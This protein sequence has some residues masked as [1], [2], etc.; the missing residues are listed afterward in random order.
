MSSESDG[1]VCVKAIDGEQR[2]TPQIHWWIALDTSLS[3]STIVKDKTRWDLLKEVM[4]ILLGHLRQN[5]PKDSITVSTFSNYCDVLVEN[6]KAE[7]VNL[8]AIRCDQSTNLQSVFESFE[9]WLIRNPESRV[10]Q[11]VLT[12]GEPTS[13]ITVPEYL[14]ALQR[15]IVQNAKHFVKCPVFTWFAAI[16]KDAKWQTVKALAECSSLSMWIHVDE[17]KMSALASDVGNLVGALTQGQYY[18]VNNEQVLVIGNTPHYFWVKNMPDDVKGEVDDEL[19]CILRMQN[20]IRSVAFP[21]RAD[22]GKWQ[23]YLGEIAPKTEVAQRHHGIIQA[24]LA[25]LDENILY[26]TAMQD[27]SLSRQA[28]Q[29]SQESTSLAAEFASQFAE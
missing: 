9:T 15:R 20:A 18:T 7:A 3:M 11:L 24:Q 23:K 17:D 16:S 6:V 13:G 1:A 2:S 28:S 19:V 5:R 26:G 8:D 12:D 14:V 27:F 29:A 10:A 25:N 22:V 21:T 4:R